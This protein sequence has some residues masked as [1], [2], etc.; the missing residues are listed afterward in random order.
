MAKPID[1]V[2]SP[3]KLNFT[4]LRFLLWCHSKLQ[5]FAASLHYI[6]SNGNA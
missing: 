2:S 6:P 5:P 1:S 4:V 3:D